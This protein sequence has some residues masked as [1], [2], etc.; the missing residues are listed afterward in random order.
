M[1]ST[2]ETKIHKGTSPITDLEERRNYRLLQKPDPK[3]DS[4]PLTVS[5]LLSHYAQ[6]NNTSKKSL[7]LMYPC[8]CLPS[9][10]VLELVPS[11]T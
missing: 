3:P 9:W 5:S 11:W 6:S 7:T 2:V 10:L 1:D 8:I 4:R